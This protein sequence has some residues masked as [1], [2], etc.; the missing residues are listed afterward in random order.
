MVAL[1][2]YYTR[3]LSKKGKFID[4]HVD[5]TAGTL[6]WSGRAKDKIKGNKDFINATIGSA[7]EDDGSLMILPIIKEE[8]CNLS[9]M[10]LFGYANVRG[11]PDY[12]EAWN[13]D[14]LESYPSNL[15]KKA[16]E[17]STLP[18][19]ACGGLTGGITV[20]GQVFFTP[21]DPILA[22]NSR[23]GNVD[24]VLFSN[25]R[26]TEVTYNLL[27]EE[28]ELNF[29]H[30]IEQLENASKKYDKIGV[31]FNFPNNPSGISPT[32]N[33]IIMLQKALKDIDIPTIILLDDAYEGYVYEEDAINHS[34]FP[35]LIGLNENVIVIKIDGVSKRYCAYGMRLGNVT[36][37]FGGP[38]DEETK[39]YMREM[40]AKGARTI[41]SSSPRG[42]QHAVAKILNNPKK[43]KQLKEQQK[44]NFSILKRRYQLVKEYVL[45]NENDAFIPAKFNSGFF[46]YFLVEP[47]YSAVK[48]SYELL[49][50]GLG[51][52]PFVNDHTHLNGIRVAFCSVSETKI[53]KAM[54]I[55]Y[56][57]KK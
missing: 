29:A 13:R 26:L 18:A 24:N 30:L 33:Q 21:H 55:L 1:E 53:P 2:H 35:Y 39:Y 48:I 23:W 19:T 46:A 49:E 44:R 50:R 14:T 31:Y 36:I 42:I 17:L 28:G 47:H 4:E 54:D 16:E 25:H 43:R 9:G 38:V 3:F 22:P 40:M 8:L 32:H 10:D 41:S 15:R 20:A 6:A 11:I 56:S 52:V 5:L 51:T 7:T 57:I 34:I 37:G 27:D 12:V 45:E